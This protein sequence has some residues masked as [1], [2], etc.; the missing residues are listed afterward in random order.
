MVFWHGVQLGAAA[1]ISVNVDDV[2]DVTSR[3]TIDRCSQEPSQHLLCITTVVL[4][5]KPCYGWIEYL[6]VGIGR[7]YQRP[8][9]LGE[10]DE[11]RNGSAIVF[12][13]DIHFVS[14]FPV[15]NLIPQSLARTRIHM[16]QKSSHKIFPM[17][18]TSASIRVDIVRRITA[19]N[20]RSCFAPCSGIRIK[21]GRAIVRVENILRSAARV[22]IG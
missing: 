19:Q 21:D 7:Q 14:R 2:G 12:S 10:P 18:I 13:T 4:A 17:L 5:T 9:I 20:G 16:S 3:L 15:G 6:C 1:Y 8:H 22:P 11:L